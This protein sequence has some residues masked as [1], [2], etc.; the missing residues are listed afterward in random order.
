MDEAYRQAEG[1]P[2]QELWGAVSLG[3]H[4]ASSVWPQMDGI[5]RYRAARLVFDLETLMPGVVPPN[6]V[7]RALQ[8]FRG[9]HLTGFVEVLEQRSRSPWQALASYLSREPSRQSM[10]ELFRD[11][12][13]DGRHA[14]LPPG[15]RRIPGPPPGRSKASQLPFD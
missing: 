5:D 2:W 15:R 8:V 3:K 7:R 4:P 6:R 12:E 14:R 11:A 13:N 1:S 9:R 10:E